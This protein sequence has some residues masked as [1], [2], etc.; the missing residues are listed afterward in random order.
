MLRRWWPYWIGPYWA[1]CGLAGISV[2]QCVGDALAAEHC[3]GKQWP[4]PIPV[5]EV[6]YCTPTLHVEGRTYEWLVEWEGGTMEAHT[7]QPNMTFKPALSDYTRVAVRIV[8]DGRASPWSNGSKLHRFV[9]LDG[10]LS[11]GLSDLFKI[12]SLSA[13]ICV[14]Q[15]WGTP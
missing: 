6:S 2:G 5:C 13:M 10:D 8:D 15:R 11:Y 3:V 14:I 7:T 4:D 12:R 1:A 9:S